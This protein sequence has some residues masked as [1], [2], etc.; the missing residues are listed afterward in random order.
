MVE[1]VTVWV[2]PAT[3]RERLQLGAR[4]SA[5]R[6]GGQAALH[7]YLVITPISQGTCLEY[8]NTTT[9]ITR[10]ML[11]AVLVG[12]QRHVTLQLVAA[13]DGLHVA[14]VSK[15]ASKWGR[16]MHGHSKHNHSKYTFT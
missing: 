9:T 4:G 12:E 10:Y 11:P 13:L 14:I 8:S 5:C 6:P 3:I 7:S 2:R 16:S 15:K 1:A